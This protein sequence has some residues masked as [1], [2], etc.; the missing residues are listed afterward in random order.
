M[1]SWY[2]GCD[3]FCLHA[4]RNPVRKMGWIAHPTPMPPPTPIPAKLIGVP[5]CIPILEV[6]LVSIIVDNAIK[7]HKSTNE[8]LS[9]TLKLKCCLHH[10]FS[11]LIMLHSEVV[12]PC[13]VTDLA[14]D[15]IHMLLQMRQMGLMSM[16]M[17]LSGPETPQTGCGYSAR[18][19]LIPDNANSLLSL[20]QRAFRKQSSL[21]QCEWDRTSRWLQT[22]P[23]LQRYFLSLPPKPQPTPNPQPHP[24]PIPMPGPKKFW[25]PIDLR[26]NV[27]PDCT[28]ASGSSWLACI[29]DTHSYDQ[30]MTMYW[31]WLFLWQVVIPTVGYPSMLCCI[32]A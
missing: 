22:R 26:S 25:A 19:S 18:T 4:Q 17:Q 12:V 27:A 21:M 30:G 8:E 28:P 31:V 9:Q 10:N 6:D 11:F 3:L 15:H 23:S 32:G 14:A 1:Q 20:L 5:A 13:T 24:N 2:K 16:W 29:D 7:V